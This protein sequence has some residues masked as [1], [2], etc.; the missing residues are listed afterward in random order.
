MALAA[1][2]T[3]IANEVLLAADLNALNTNILDNAL[4]LISPWTAN[5][6]A[7][8]FRLITLGAGTVG[9]P[10]VEFSGDTDSGFYRAAADQVSLAAAGSQ[11]LQASGYTGGVNYVRV[12]AAPTNSPPLI[13]SLGTDTNVNLR[14][15][16]QGTGYVIVSPGGIAG[17]RLIPGLVGSGDEG[18]GL[19]WITTGTLDLVGSQSRV[20]S[21]IGA[22]GATN[23]VTITATATG[24]GPTL[25]VAGGDTNV[26]L[27]I[28]TKGGGALT[29]GSS[30]TGG[31][32][33][34]AA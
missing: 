4:S 1:V 25:S 26:A 13:G 6:D 15:V 5:M 28:D 2:K 27:T 22:Q 3:F 14:L 24:T 21:A 17:S 12:A 29:L 20:L 18:T 10:S 33:G 9:N 32:Q 31:V 23:Y 11:V 30:D 8:G 19:T 16:P 34:G 7:G